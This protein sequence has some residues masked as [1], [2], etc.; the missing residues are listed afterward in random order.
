[1]TL[2]ALKIFLPRRVTDILQCSSPET[3]QG[4]AVV[5][6]NGGFS[7]AV[8]CILVIC[9]KKFIHASYDI[10]IYILNFIIWHAGYCH[11]RFVETC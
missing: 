5:N 10:F 7:V 1:Y 3:G 11:G 9:Q 6:F 8:Y 2:L 4:M